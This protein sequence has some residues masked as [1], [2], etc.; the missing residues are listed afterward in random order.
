[1]YMSNALKRNPLGRGLLSSGR[2]ALVGGLFLV[3]AA[4]LA[5]CGANE[6]I[7]QPTQ[8]PPPT[9]VLCPEQQPCPEPLVSDVP[10]AEDWAGS[11]HADAESES[12][13]HWNEEDP[14]EVPATCAKCHS[15]PGMLDF[16]GADGSAPESVDAPAPIGSTVECAA[17]HN[18]ATLTL[19]SV[20]FPSG[21]VLT[22][23]GE[24]AICL[25]CHQGRASRVQVDAA[26]E[27][28]GATDDDAV[29]ADL[30][31]TNIHYYAAAVARYGTLVK[32][33]YEYD[34]QPYDVLF[35]HVEGVTECADCHNPHT[36]EVELDGCTS[37]HPGVA[38][39]EDLRNIRMLSSV[40]DY[41]GDGDVAEGVFY[42]LE[43][44]RELLFTAI[45]SYA[46]EVAGAPIVYDSGAHPY[47]F[48]DTNDNG[49]V[50]EGEAVSDNRFASW[51]PRLAKAAFNFQTSLKDP[52]AYAH[53][54]KYIM[55]LV[56]D[57][58]ADL[59]T[60]LS[61]PVSLETAHR[62]D[63]GHF[64]GSSEAFRHWDAEEGIVPAACVRCHTA[65]G[66]PMFLES[67]ATINTEASNGLMC[68][69]CHNDLTTWTRYEVAE[70]RF[71]SGAVLS[72]EDADNNLCMQCHQGRE[73]TTSVNATINGLDPD[74]PNERLRFRNVH[75]FAAASTLFGTEAKGV[76]EYEGKTYL[77]QFAHTEN[78]ASCTD[79]HDTHALE[80]QTDQCSGCH[81]TENPLDIRWS[82]STA[83]YDGDGDVTEG[84]SG[85][86][87]TMSESLLAAIQAYA[88]DTLQ[89]PIAYSPTAYPYWFA[90]ANNNGTVD[91]GEEG[92]ASWS[93]RLL[94]AAYNY[95]Y[96]QKDPGAFAHNAKYVLQ[97][98]YDS[99]EDV[100][101]SVTGMTRP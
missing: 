18:E 75:Y 83:D 24:S 95:Q 5:A 59:N 57:S 63:V 100:G 16:L 69:T 89:A 11:G 71:P 41:D 14:K 23:L 77:G 4:F 34:G 79:C 35:E 17:C 15:T 88:A 92:Y 98:L 60:V 82:T 58:I 96:Y 33:G 36:L 50:D 25:N 27:Q 70:V 39:V 52:G 43:G 29:T 46:S 54:G 93:P 87:A 49:Q 1:M 97:V 61:T 30:G 80:V 13:V 31:F 21:A 28:A 19:S 67:G 76:Y 38:S 72:M 40:V 7:P 68:E 101:G 6:P 47:F 81:Q 32:G 86:L 56:Y 99:I 42:E 3:L 94:T 48:N 26:I 45:Q 12:F 8:P 73:S 66:V 78:F 62:T 55:E 64:D 85:E 10:F 20:T 37:C 74:T 9:P 84:I 53:G 51:T 90:D 65:E 91:E 22:G 2:Y 44:M